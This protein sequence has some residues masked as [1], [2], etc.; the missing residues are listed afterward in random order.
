MGYRFL[1]DVIVAIHVGYVSY[2]VVGQLLIWLGIV[3]RWQWIRNPW[4][5]WTHLIMILIV[6]IEAVFAIE[7]PLTRWESKL[8]LLAGQ[9]VSGESFV[10]RL[11]HD[12]I[13]VDWPEWVINSLH[14]TFALLVLGTFLL[15]PPRRRSIQLAGENEAPISKPPPAIG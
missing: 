1:A 4:F 14:I 7:C 6:G 8:R 12:L 9:Q 10:G 3:F 5:R 2:V 11:L 15:V 13:F